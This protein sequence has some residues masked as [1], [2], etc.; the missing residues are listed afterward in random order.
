MHRRIT[1]ARHFINAAIGILQLTASHTCPATWGEDAPADSQKVNSRRPDEQGRTSGAQNDERNEL[2]GR[3][4][5]QIHDSALQGH[6]GREGTVVAVARDFYWPLMQ[7]LI[8]R[9]IRNCDICGRSKI[10]REHKQ[11]LLQPLPVPERYFKHIQ[12]DSMIDYSVAHGNISVWV[13][14]CQLSKNSGIETHV[15][16]E[17]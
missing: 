2:K 11:G 15:L 4:V 5:Q 7:Q 8:R 3:L 1:E 16:D 17:C 10:W 12:I 6:L 13:I 14:K 9:F